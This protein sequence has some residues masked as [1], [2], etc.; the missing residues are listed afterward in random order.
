MNGARGAVALLPDVRH[1]MREGGH[2]GFIGAPGKARVGEIA[3]GLRVALQR[4]QH[5][6][7][8][9]GEQIAKLRG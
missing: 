3:S 1:F 7:Q 2:D 9:T 8:G 4:H 6:G 5:M